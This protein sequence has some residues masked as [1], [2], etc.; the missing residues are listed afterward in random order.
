MLR[1]AQHQRF[2]RVE[3]KKRVGGPEIRQR[4]FNMALERVVRRHS[5]TIEGQPAAERIVGMDKCCRDDGVIR[6]R[7]PWPRPQCA[8]IPEWPVR[9]WV[10]ARCNRRETLI[11]AIGLGTAEHRIVAGAIRRAAGHQPVSTGSF[12]C[13]IDDLGAK[14]GHYGHAHVVAFDGN[15]VEVAMTGYANRHLLSP[16]DA[17]ARA[18]IRSDRTIRHCPMATATINSRPSA[19]S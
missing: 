8:V 14:I 13:Q 1:V 12:V 16:V 17:M 7:L 11:P 5:I 4:A 18:C 15:D 6:G 2:A 19:T 9:V 3:S 10:R